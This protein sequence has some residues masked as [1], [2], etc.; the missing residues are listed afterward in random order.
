MQAQN[1]QA[2]PSGPPPIL[3]GNSHVFV[4]SASLIASYGGQQCA[5]TEGDVLQLNP[6]PSPDP[7]Y[8][9]VQVLASKAQDCRVSQ[10]VPVQLLDLQ[11]MQNNMRAS[12]DQGMNEMQNRQGQGGLPPID[13]S[14]RTQTPSPIAAEVPPPDPT[15]AAQLQQQAQDAGRQEEQALGGAPNTNMEPVAAPMSGP[16]PSGGSIQLGQTTDQ[17]IAIMGKPNSVAPG[18]GTKTYVYQDL[19]VTFTNGVVTDI[20]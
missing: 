7:N 9:N 18:N 3:D 4:V 17:V 5:L 6:A 14:L 19:R 15:V 12:I 13:P 16:A 10:I 20:Q 1:P 2:A 8:A 11:D